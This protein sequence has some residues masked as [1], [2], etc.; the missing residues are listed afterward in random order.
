MDRDSAARKGAFAAMREQVAAREVDILVGTQLVAKGHD[1][2]YL[3]LVGVIGADQALVSPDFRAAERLFAQLMQVAGR[4]GRAERPGEVLIQ[5]R[6]PGHPLYQSVA[7]HDYPGFAEAA[8]RE[9]GAADFPPFVAQAVLRAE[10]KSEETALGFLMAAREVG[11]GL[12]AAVEI[13]DPVPALMHRIAGSHRLQLLVQSS[14]RP[15]LQAFLSVWLAALAEMPARG[16]RWVV[17]VDPVD[18]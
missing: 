11:L 15:R 16:V 12:E 6:Y 8:L 5:T 1:F 14:S 10:A 13:Y 7:R 18:V 4:A 3:T 17:D 9:R 2:P